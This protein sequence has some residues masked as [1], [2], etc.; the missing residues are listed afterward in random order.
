[1]EAC[2]EPAMA[3]AWRVPDDVETL[4]LPRRRPRDPLASLPGR[5]GPEAE[6]P[7]RGHDAGCAARR[8]GDDAIRLSQPLAFRAP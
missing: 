4:P 1:M 5:R 7:R 3:K 8:S 2:G 6:V